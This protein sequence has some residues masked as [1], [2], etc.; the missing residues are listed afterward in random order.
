MFPKWLYCFVLV[1]AISSNEDST[2]EF[3]GEDRSDKWVS[4]KIEQ[5]WETHGQHISSLLKE[6]QA[7]TPSPRAF[8]NKP[9]YLFSLLPANKN[10]TRDSQTKSH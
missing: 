1:Y 10:G 4:G 7:L 5:T 9:S 6:G 8:S 3:M 2:T